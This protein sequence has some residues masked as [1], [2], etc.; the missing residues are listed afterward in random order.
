MIRFLALSLLFHLVLF[1]AVYFSV[2]GTD[3]SSG[4][5]KLN[6][7]AGDV[8][9]G[10]NPLAQTEKQNSAP[11][12]S[13]SR[14]A[15]QPGE[16]NISAEP[17]EAGGAQTLGSTDGEAKPEGISL[18]YP[19]LSVRLG[20]TGKVT[21]ALFVTASGT[22]D[23]AKV[24]RSSGFSRLDSAALV[25]LSSAHYSPAIR[26]GAAVASS[27]EITVEFRLSNNGAPA[28][29]QILSH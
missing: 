6:V 25:A 1:A 4:E 18:P 28:Q 14:A 20:E 13:P 5:V 9:V 15:P 29:A 2:R 16:M 7:S 21:V 19:A 3:S 24:I 23:N 27:K 11:S 12:E 8:F 22:P 17:A 10:K 26:G